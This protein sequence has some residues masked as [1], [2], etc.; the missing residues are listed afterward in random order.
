MSKQDVFF[1]LLNNVSTTNLR[2]YVTLLIIIGT[3]IDYWVF[4]DKPANE[5]LMFLAA[6]SGI[7]T[8]QFHSKRKTHNKFAND[9]ATEVV[10]VPD[11]VATTDVQE[12]YEKG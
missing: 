12:L 8:A 3:A 4:G 1:R 10:A 9:G 5:W 2:I 6:L 11:V 7:D